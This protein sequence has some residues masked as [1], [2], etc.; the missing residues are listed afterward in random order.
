MNLDWIAVDDVSQDD[1]DAFVLNLRLLIQDSDGFS[2]HCLS[3]IYEKDEIPKELSVEFAKQR[4]KWKTHLISMTLIKKAGRNENYSN[5]ELF[6]T[7]FYGG[8]AHQ[9]KKYIKEFFVLTKQGFFSAF[10]F[11]NFL[12]SLNTIL[13]VVRNIREINKKLIEISKR[14]HLHLA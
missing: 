11:G 2:I 10:V 6:N 9:D 1:V 12:S 7:L 4:Q 8:L 5:D 14:Q 13:N 3:K